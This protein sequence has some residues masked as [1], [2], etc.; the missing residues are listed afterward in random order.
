MS[1][2]RIPA[3]TVLFLPIFPHLGQERAKRVCDAVRACA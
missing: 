3:R 1:Q 2:E